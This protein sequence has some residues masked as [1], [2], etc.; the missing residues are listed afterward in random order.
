MLYV[1]DKKRYTKNQ[2]KRMGIKD[3]LKFWFKVLIETHPEYNIYTQG[4]K[5]TWT[6]NDAI[7]YEIYDLEWSSLE[8]AQNKLK[9]K[10]TK[11]IQEHINNTVKN[12]WYDSEN[13]IAKYL[14][15]WNPFEPECRKISL[16]IWNTWVSAITIMRDI[17]DGKA[18][19]PKNI[20]DELPVY[21]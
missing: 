12:L 4:V 18:S 2:I 8:S 6:E 15:E 16:W 13:N 11:E 20:I 5:D 3:P 1:K 21:K 7:V 10:L 14:T 17:K 19:I 9:V